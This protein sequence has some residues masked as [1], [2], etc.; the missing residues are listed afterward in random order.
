M[1]EFKVCPNSWQPSLI[2]EIVDSVLKSN[3]IIKESYEIGLSFYNDGLH[4]VGLIIDNKY[5]LQFDYTRVMIK[6]FSR[7]QLFNYTESFTTISYGQLVLI[8]ALGIQFPLSIENYN[9]C[10]E[11]VSRILYNLQN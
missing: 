4:H 1:I 2:L 6:N 5:R 11:L 8:I 9:T 3:F 10:T 7:R